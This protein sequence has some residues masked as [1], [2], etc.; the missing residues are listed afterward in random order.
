MKI[1]IIAAG[2]IGGTLTRRLRLWA[3]LKARGTHCASG[4][5]RRPGSQGHSHLILTSLHRVVGERGYCT[6]AEL[7]YFVVRT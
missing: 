6:T 4:F 1:G 5:G 7:H 3:G 2:Q